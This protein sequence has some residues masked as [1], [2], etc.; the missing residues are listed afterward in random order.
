MATQAMAFQQ[1]WRITT[2]IRIADYHSNWQC[3]L[4][5]QHA[6]CNC[7]QSIGPIK[8]LKG[9]PDHCLD[10]ANTSQHLPLPGGLLRVEYHYIVDQSL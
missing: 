6:Y 9:S 8:K 7:S 1:L 2:V 5:Q 3:T 4:P 10:D